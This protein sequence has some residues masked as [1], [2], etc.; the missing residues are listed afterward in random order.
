MDAKTLTAPAVTDQ[1]GLQDFIDALQ[2]YAPA[3]ERDVARLRAAPGDREVIGS[4]FR[5]LHNVKGDAVLCKVDLAVAITHP[6]ETVLSR[7]R[8]NDFSFT[9]P[10]AE[11]FLLAVDRLELAT[12]RLAQ[13]ESLVGLQLVPLVQGLEE[14]AQ[15]AP[16]DVDECV[17]AT[18]E[19][20]TG[21]R[22]V[23][24]PSL[25]GRGRISAI[26]SGASSQV[27]DDLRFFQTL[28]NQF[29]GRSPLFKGRTM[30]VL[31]LARETN[32]LAGDMIDT[33]QLEAAVY[34]HDVGMM[35]LPESEWLKPNAMTPA[36]KLSLRAHPGYAAGMLA[37]I[38]GW[39]AAAEMVAQHHEMPDGQGYPEGLEA[40]R[41]CA[42]AKV[43][44]IIDAFEAVMLKH[45]NRGRNRSI[46]R[47][48]AEINACDKQFAPEWIAPFNQVI[49]RN[50]EM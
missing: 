44:A 18:I 25:R 11:V 34:M 6:I 50:L 36:E 32:Q 5:T 15:A 16:V 31:R 38:D 26:H 17:A 29:E 27:A 22:P 47:A 1:E 42:G 30:R 12:A 7:V 14:L 49:R 41:I 33:Q 46:L 48:I 40:G 4:L 37:R 10:V 23:A 45:I 24:T 21:F 19:A 43:L 35:F 3:I 2:D 13:Q 39:S 20:V 28:A 9:D 8:G